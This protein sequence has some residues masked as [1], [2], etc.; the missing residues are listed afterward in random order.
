MSSCKR[1]T[2]RSIEK[3]NLRK[4]LQ[5]FYA[6][7]RQR[8]SLLLADIRSD[9]RRQVG[10]KGGD[11]Y[12]PFWADAKDHVGGIADLR[13]RSKARVESNKARARLYPL[14]ANGFLKLW[15]EKARWRNE[16]FDFVPTN[17]SARFSIA[18]LGAVV[19]VENVAAVRLQDGS[20][21]IVYPYFSERPALP[22]EGARLGFWAIKEALAD[23][24]IEDV[25]VIDIL[26][27]AYFRPSEDPARGDERTIFI[28]KYDS[29]L[30][31]WRK[32]KEDLE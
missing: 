22:T 27:S 32:L 18:E 1:F 25:R 16:A 17:V 6:D 9:L 7:V 8:R 3:I 21:R 14:L 12:A 5:L 15:N 29:L 31:E 30:R 26:R 10:E 24:A 20:Y 4:L 13:D 2:A 28:Q 11:F 19:K 23:F